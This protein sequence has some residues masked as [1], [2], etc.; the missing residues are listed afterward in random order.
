MRSLYDD[1]EPFRTHRF[2]R[3]Q[4]VLWVEE[5]GNPAGIP[6]LF[7]HGGPGS[8]CK[9]HHRRFFDPSRFRILLHDQR[10]SGHSKD[11]WDLDS[12]NTHEILQDLKFIREA[13]GLSRWLLFGGSWG[14]TLAL[15]YAQAWPLT[16]IAMVLRGTFLGRRRDLDWFV[17]PLGV[18]TIYPEAWRD[19]AK[20]TAMDED[21]ATIESLYTKVCSKNPK[22]RW[23]TA[24]AWEAWGATVTLGQT[25]RTNL[26]LSDDRALRV[27]QQSTIELHFAHNNYFIH[28]NQIIEDIERISGL[29]T[30]IVHGAR[31]LVCPCDTAFL[32]NQLIPQSKLYILENSGHV[33]SDDA[34]ISTLI[35]ATEEIAD[36]GLEGK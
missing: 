15:L 33:P 23:Q 28:E 12:N 32:L 8:G 24:R 19:L 9:V 10:G 18:R 2:V 29:P 17:G 30:A 26:K 31:D 21:K 25:S 5:S 27:I 7:L 3:N 14:A 20:E 35:E 1:I 4:Q 22:V 11:R 16:V 34:M 13:L 36:I 6:V